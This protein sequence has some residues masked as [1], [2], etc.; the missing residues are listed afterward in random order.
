MTD[1]AVTG[2]KRSG[3]GLFCAGLIR[4]ALRSGRRVATNMD[5]HLGELLL[6]WNKSTIIRLPDCPTVEDMECIGL[7]Y[8][9]E[10]DG[11]IDEEQN[12]IIVLD[13]TSKFFNARQWGDK[14]RQPL[15]DWLIHSGK[16]RWHVYYQMQ[17]LTQ[18]DK[19]IRDTQI[20]YHIAVKRT[21]RW[22]IPGVTA[23]SKLVGLDV[24]FP[25]M[26]I[27]IVKHGCDRDSLTVDRKWYRAKDLYKA[28]DTEQKFLDREHPAAVGLH[29]V[30][31]P[32]HVD[33]R[34][35]PKPP[36]KPLLFLYGLIGYDYVSKLRA[37]RNTAPKRKPKHPLAAKL[38]KLSEADAIR[39]FNRLES[40]GAFRWHPPLSDDPTLRHRLAAV[41]FP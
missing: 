37:Q 34:Y 26:H 2:K 31:S 35:L 9:V 13:E 28:Y 22:P 32:W 14:T 39:H 27:G 29:T 1:F 21:D 33:G 16:K 12:G 40:A 23:L 19:Q 18:V 8:G 25:K 5:I 3:K 7:G 15:L 30:L 10:G 4:D 6:P 24:R 38:A 41:Q 11:Q 20:E 36:V 17:G